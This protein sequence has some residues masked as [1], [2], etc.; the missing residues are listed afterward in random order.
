MNDVMAICVAVVVSVVIACMSIIGIVATD[1][2]T[3]VKVACIENG[4]SWTGRSG[5]CIKG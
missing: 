2:G 3:K 4:G 1:N 5:V